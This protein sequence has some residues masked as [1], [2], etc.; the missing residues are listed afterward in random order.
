MNSNPT[1]GPGRR[2]AGAG[3]RQAYT[4]YLDRGLVDRVRR[5]IGERDVVRSIEAALEAA[6]DYQL[7]VRETA[8]GRRDVLS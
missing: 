2:T 6:L 8:S 7:W 3:A 5:E 4:F 1:G